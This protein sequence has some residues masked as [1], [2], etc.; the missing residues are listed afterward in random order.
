VRLQGKDSWKLDSVEIFVARSK[1]WRRLLALGGHAT[2]DHDHGQDDTQSQNDSQS[3]QKFV[4]AASFE[5][6]EE[7][8]RSEIESGSAG[9]RYF[10]I[11][12]SWFG[13]DGIYTRGLGITDSVEVYT[14]TVATADVPGAGTDSTVT[15][16]LHGD[17][18][19]SGDRILDVSSTNVNKFEQGQVDVF[20]VR[21][22]TLGTIVSLVVQ[23]D[24]KGHGCNWKVDSIAVHRKAPHSA[25]RYVF[26]PGMSVWWTEKQPQRELKGPT[27]ESVAQRRAALEPPSRGLLVGP[28][29]LL[30]MAI[31]SGSRLANAG[32]ALK[33]LQK[34]V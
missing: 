10:C 8:F 12:D 16:N 6:A 20:V 25:D 4:S 15:I 23:I 31:A 9:A 2:L 30:T 29:R 26:Y 5:L 32:T 24:G 33:F 11:C 1:L 13:R 21:C 19:A 27:K 7:R 17:I 3:L 14:I 34:C 18:A 28:R 22:G